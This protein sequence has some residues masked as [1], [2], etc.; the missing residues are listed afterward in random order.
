MLWT[1]GVRAGHLSEQAFVAV[2][3][4]N[5]ARI[6]GLAGAQ[7]RARAGRGRRHRGLGPGR[8][9]HRHQANRHGRVDYTPYEGMHLLGGPARSTCAAWR[10]TATARSWPSPAAASFLERASAQAAPGPAVR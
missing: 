5:Q 2:L 10:P 8:D 3:S 1:H 4:T 7:G 6:H 9:G